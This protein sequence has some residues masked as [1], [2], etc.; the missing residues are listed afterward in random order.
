VKRDSSCAIEITSTGGV[1]ETETTWVSPTSAGT[2]NSTDSF[3]VVPGGEYVVSFENRYAGSILTTTTSR[4][5]ETTSNPAIL[6]VGK[7]VIAGNQLRTGNVV[8]EITC[9]ASAAAD[10][11]GWPKKLTVNPS[12]RER[13]ITVEVPGDEANRDT[14]RIVETSDGIEQQTAG[15]IRPS[16]DSRPW[17]SSKVQELP[18]GRAVPISGVSSTG[19]PVE[20]SVDGP[21]RI[22]K[23]RIS[24]TDGASDCVV[25][26]T[27]AGRPTRE[28]SIAYPLG[29]VATTTA[30]AQRNLSVTNAY[31][32]QSRTITR[33]RQVR[34]VELPPCPLTVKSAGS[35]SAFGTTRLIRE[36]S[37][38]QG[39]EIVKVKTQCTVSGIATR[40]DFR[41]CTFRRDGDSVLVTTYGRSNVRVNVTI[42]A[43]GDGYTKSVWKRSYR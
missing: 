3:S 34:T 36:M 15:T 8:V 33:T 39:C 17:R 26:F 4:V 32:G 40:G 20:T 16:W 7:E 37:S 10:P 12:S 31:S 24:A 2:G 22:R 1:V 19:S 5:I 13:T 35:I 9:A 28:V 23:G 18:I 25:T 27:A 30:G 41:N 21:C 14:C 11:S 43:K 42:V 38:G 6:T 29:Q